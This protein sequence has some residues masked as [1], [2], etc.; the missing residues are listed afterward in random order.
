MLTNQHRL[1]E[2]LAKDSPSR[3]EREEI[4]KLIRSGKY[5]LP[6]TVFENSFTLLKEGSSNQSTLPSIKGFTK[7]TSSS[8]LEWSWAS[9]VNSK[10]I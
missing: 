1:H 10:A 7:L 8:S 4:L 6:E 2:L 5:D 9:A 3:K